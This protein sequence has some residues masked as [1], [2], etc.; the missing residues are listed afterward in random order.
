MSS[1]PAAAT[2]SANGNSWRTGARQPTIVEELGEVLPFYLVMKYAPHK[3]A[4]SYQLKR[5]RSDK[6]DGYNRRWATRLEAEAA[7]ADFKAWVNDQM[8]ALERKAGSLGGA[9]V[10]ALSAAATASPLPSR[11]SRRAPA[12]PLVVRAVVS[13]AAK[14][15]VVAVEVGA[16]M[17]SAPVSWLDSGTVCM[18]T[19]VVYLYCFTGTCRS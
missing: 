3:N 12:I 1:T 5:A 2:V 15:G 16:R 10:A 18:C 6:R 4:R 17:V 11:F 7:R 19:A 14:P 13:L 9:A 8:F